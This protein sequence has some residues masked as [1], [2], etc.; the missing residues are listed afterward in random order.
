MTKV[1]FRGEFCKGCGLCVQV[2][3]RQIIKLGEYINSMG[4]HS[5]EIREPERC[6]GCA[7]C[8]LMC[9]DLVI[10]VEKEEQA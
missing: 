2:C 3:P 8:A 4:Y 9:P 7:F 1:S 5:A 10:T 6:I